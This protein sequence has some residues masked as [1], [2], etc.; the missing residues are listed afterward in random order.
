M[1]FDMSPP[2]DPQPQGAEPPRTNE[3]AILAWMAFLLRL[4]CGLDRIPPGYNLREDLD[5]ALPILLRGRNPIR[6]F[7]LQRVFREL[8]TCLKEAT[9]PVNGQENRSDCARGLL[10]LDPDELSRVIWEAIRRL[11]KTI[12]QK[13]EVESPEEEEIQILSLEARGGEKLDF[14]GLCGG[15][16]GRRGRRST[17]QKNQDEEEGHT[18]HISTFRCRRGR[19]QWSRSR[20]RR[21]RVL[22]AKMRRKH[23]AVGKPGSMVLKY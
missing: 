13:R 4:R 9:D 14:W 16:S 11:V 19:R 22:A 12:P 10:E 17:E 15:R 20:T 6:L 21:C 5:P 2:M 8:Q 3:E 23:A 7:S 18:T 1:T